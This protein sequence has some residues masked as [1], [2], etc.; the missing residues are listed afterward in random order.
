MEEKRSRHYADVANWVESIMNSCET[1]RQAITSRN[2][3]RNWQRV[4][5]EKV[6]YNVYVELY[7]RLTRSYDSIFLD[8]LSVS[9]K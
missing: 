3:M 9:K 5:E 6:P 7:T 2:L 8:R 4:Y 1:P